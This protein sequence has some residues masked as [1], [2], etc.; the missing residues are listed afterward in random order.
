MKEKDRAR[1]RATKL[2][3]EQRIE[4][5]WKA[6]ESSHSDAKARGNVLSVP[7]CFTG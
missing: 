7:E 2:N 6:N 5:K 3:T 4:A 1:A